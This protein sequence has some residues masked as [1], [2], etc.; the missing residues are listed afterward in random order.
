MKSHAIIDKS[1]NQFEGKPEYKIPIF[2]EILFVHRYLWRAYWAQV[3]FI[4]ES[5]SILSIETK[6]FGLRTMDE[7]A[8]DG[9]MFKTEINV[10][11]EGERISFIIFFHSRPFNGLIAVVVITHHERALEFVDI[12]QQLYLYES[13]SAT[14]KVGFTKSSVF[15][16][17]F[18]L[19]H[20][21]L[22]T[23]HI[24]SSQ[25]NSIY[26]VTYSNKNY[27]WT[28]ESSQ[29]LGISSTAPY[30]TIQS[31]NNNKKKSWNSLNKIIQSLESRGYGVWTTCT[32]IC[33][34]PTT[35]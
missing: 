4:A 32:F 19:I 29:T 23:T 6:Y 22:P 14:V 28:S 33:V 35:H 7:V 24:Y 11:I 2:R 21:L 15:F 1:P 3:D 18:S 13:Y 26:L 10:F 16:H 20:S 9:L 34:I 25:V 5:E 8:I 30:K 27:Y 12:A 17:H 31:N